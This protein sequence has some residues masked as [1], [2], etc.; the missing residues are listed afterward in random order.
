[1]TAFNAFVLEL[2]FVGGERD[3]SAMGS[4]VRSDVRALFGDAF[5]HVEEKVAE[6]ARI[7]TAEVRG[8]GEWEDERELVEYVERAADEELAAALY[9]YRVE[10]FRTKRGKGGCRACG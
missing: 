2:C 6:G 5:L 10:I 9:G 3:A 8:V 1:M 4:K 7:V